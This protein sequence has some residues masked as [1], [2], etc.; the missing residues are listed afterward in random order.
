MYGSEKV[1]N[2]GIHCIHNTRDMFVYVYG[3]EMEVAASFTSV[4]IY[5]LL[6]GL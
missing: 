1:I 3:S 4:H 6:K 2:I 5:R